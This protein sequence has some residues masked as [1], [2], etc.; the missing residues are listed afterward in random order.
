M[1]TAYYI[2]EC[3]TKIVVEVGKVVMVVVVNSCGI[4]KQ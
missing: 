4:R 3:S 2:Y 1:E